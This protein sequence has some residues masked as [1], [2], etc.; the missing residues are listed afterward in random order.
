M[1]RFAQLGRTRRVATGIMA[2]VLASLLGG[3]VAMA[4]G[5]AIQTFTPHSATRSRTSTCCASRSGTTTAIRWAP[6]SSPRTATTRRRPTRSQAGARWLAGRTA[7]RRDEGDRP[8]RGRHD[9]GDVEL[10][11]LQQLG[12]QPEDE[13]DLR[14]RPAVPGRS[15]HGG[16]GQKAAKEGYAIIWITGRPRP[17][18][19]HARQ[20]DVGR[21]RGR[22]RLSRADHAQRRRGGLFTKP[23]V[24]SY[25]AYLK[26][27][28]A[29]EI[30]GG[31]ACTTIH[32]KSATRA[33]I[34]SLGYEIVADFGDQFSDL[35]GG[36]ADPTFKLPNP[37]YSCR[38]P[39]AI[40]TGEGPDSHRGRALLLIRR[41]PRRPEACHLRAQ[42]R[43]PP[44][45]ASSRWPGRY[46]AIDMPDVVAAIGI[47]ASWGTVVV[48]WVAG[49]VY[50]AWRAPQR[51]RDRSGTAAYV[52]VVAICAAIVSL[53]YGY[54]HALVFDAAWARYL[55]LAVL[56]ASTVLSL[57]ARFALGTMW[58]VA[59]EVGGDRRLRTSGPYGVTR[60]PIY[61]G[62]L[63]MLLG[64]ALLVGGHELVALVA[65]GL[66]VFEVK[67]HQEER[68]MVA[69]FPREYPDYRRRV[70][71]LVPGL[72]WLRLRRAD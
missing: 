34:E 23:A 41:S 67:I 17:G 29:A 13:R 63:G 43:D 10:R 32:Y 21:Y 12:L 19:R 11:A 53:G 46:D 22:C 37:N 26:A 3:A 6:G 49:A 60:H 4:A 65:V 72:R 5:P 2:L 1:R 28:C 27:A 30:A 45:I 40:T 20:P 35:T 15:G 42:R 52:V 57:W 69:T 70:P 66:V 44:G 48:V 25:P 36:F 24:A 16:H 59:P 68:L 64:T 7:R 51:T 33:H 39:G 56:V 61:S 50:N 8:R 71:Q 58:S 31:S 62:L 18:G 55:G 54:F 38:S 9:A 14:V 47:G